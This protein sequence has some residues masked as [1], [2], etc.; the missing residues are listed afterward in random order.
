MGIKAN[1]ISVSFLLSKDDIVKKIL[2]SK[3]PY[4]TKDQ[5]DM[6]VDSEDKLLSNINNLIKNEKDIEKAEN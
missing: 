1:L 2:A 5:I 6:I 3:N 4:L